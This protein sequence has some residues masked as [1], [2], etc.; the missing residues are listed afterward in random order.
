MAAM[1]VFVMVAWCG[2]CSGFAG[3]LVV[4]PVGRWIV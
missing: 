3:Y 1:V 2:E 4:S